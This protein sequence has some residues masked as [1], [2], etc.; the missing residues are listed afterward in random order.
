[1]GV[2]TLFYE[3]YIPMSVLVPWQVVLTVEL[4][5]L[6][7]TL[8]TALMR[9]RGEVPKLMLK[10]ILVTSD[11]LTLCNKLKTTGSSPDS[12]SIR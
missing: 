10:V 1:M 9:K 11:L 5:R 8:L 7:P 4:G 6:S 3:A 12:C 2:C